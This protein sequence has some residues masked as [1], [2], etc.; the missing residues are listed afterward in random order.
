MLKYSLRENLLTPEPDDCMAQVQDVR[1][2]SQDEIID[3]MMRRGT[4][5]TRADV[6]A[7]LQVYTE[8]VGELTADG[9]AV[10]TPLFNTSFSVS[11][12]FNGMS[13]MFDKSRHSVSVNVNAGT[14]LREAVKSV[15][16]EKT[17]GANTGPY[18]TEA[19]DVV[20]G[21]VNSAV[22]AG[23][24]LRL[25]GSRLKFDAAD[26]AQGVF[27]VPEGA[28]DAVR[29]G[30][31]AENKPARVMVMIPADIAPGTYYAEVRT[32]VDASRKQVKTL[33]VGRFG[34]VLSVGAGA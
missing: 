6:A 18:I 31:V 28:G 30:V 33:K 20:S 27:L 7:V 26:A 32:K 25:T 4:T 14:A 10:N 8:V 22:T 19:T 15:K 29:C 24:I 23:G 12:V 17:E 16:T 34:R 9:S 13:D 2:Y 5:L 11:G 1:S 21:A 3:L